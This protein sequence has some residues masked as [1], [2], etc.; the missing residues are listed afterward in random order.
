MARAEQA[1][2]QTHTV[3]DRMAP[4]LLLV[5]TLL[6]Y[7]P[8]VAARAT[9]PAGDFLDHFFP[10]SLFQHAAFAR[11][12]LP[13]W[14]PYTYS[15]HPFLADVQAAVYYPISDLLLLLSLPVTDPGWRLYLLHWD[16]ILHTW[17]GGL[18]LYWLARDLT[19]DVWAGLVGGVAF[20]LSGYLT[21]YPPLQLAVLRTA[22]WMPL[23][24]WALAHAWVAP[25][26]WRWWLVATGALVAAILAGHSQ[27]LLLTVYGTVGWVICLAIAGRHANWR[28]RGIGLAA[29]G[30]LSVALTTAQWWPSWEF[31][32]YSV[33]A[34][35]DYAFVSGGFPW[36][37]LWQ[38]LLPGVLTQY[39]PLY[40]GA[41]GLLLTGV[42]L[43]V[44]VARPRRDDDALLPGALIPW[45]GGI[46]GIALITAFGLLA[47]TG[48]NGPLFPLLYRVAPGWGYFR[49]QERAAY[50]V[51]VGLSLLAAYGV[52]LTPRLPLGVRRRVALL[53]GAGIV[54]GVYAFGLLWQL[55]GRTAVSHAAYLV[56][57]AL[58][59]I[60]GVGAAL[61]V[62]LPDWRPRRSA[63]LI[64]LIALNLIWA[65][66]GTNLSW[67]TPWARAT[68]RPE[69]AAVMGAVALSD[70]MPPGRV[71][72]EYR[73][74]DD[75][76]MV[77]GVEDVWG[78]SPLRLSAYD[79]LFT[80]FPLDRMWRLLGVQT[81]LTWRRE[82]FGPS[83][84]L[85]EWPQPTDTT[86]LHRLPGHTP[87]AWLAS[88]IV[89]ADPDAT[90]AGLADHEIS[91]D[92]TA[93]VLPDARIAP[94][95]QPPGPVTVQSIRAS[96]RRLT[97]SVDS[98]RGGLLVVSENWL[99][100]WTVLNAACDD[101]PCPTTDDTGQAY[102]TPVRADYALVG[103]RLPPGRITF[104]L[105]YQPS[106]VIIGLWV[107][108]ATLLVLVC[109]GAWRL[110]ARRER[111]P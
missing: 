7:A 37:D 68:P 99:P 31:T 79:A 39:S 83:V 62:A 52:A 35:V 16:A 91:L 111:R 20:A 59:L 51:T 110:W 44:A 14:N 15:G 87:R 58:T 47:A 86:Y 40:I 65:N 1:S 97:L 98:D 41:G 4:W 70:F 30:L 56:I 75:Y 64:G 29:V 55:P 33:R 102:L 95:D 22:V 46:I 81:V 104:D 61:L 10:F 67:G 106:S 28:G 23:L 17:L 103:V 89:V 66:M 6:F 63:W 78:S 25:Q 90:L 48:G 32:R 60:L 88:T 24:W 11:G 93:W 38:L 92:D 42:A 36:R 5:L 8:V 13:I 105:A 18:F 43:F 12:E 85:G 54:A 96:T 71:Y 73:V 80:E 74:A 109:A 72:N 45:R 21:G 108:G 3:L 9:F 107:S 27:T 84:L 101:G 69:V 77:A 82:L 34:A 57:A 19:G 50:L 26:R 53:G 100:G 94:A 49:G 76:G 2:G